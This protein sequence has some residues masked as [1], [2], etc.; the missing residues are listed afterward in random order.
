MHNRIAALLLGAGALAYSAPASAQHHDTSGTHRMPHADA[1]AHGTEQGMDH[2]MWSA[3]LG[4]GWRILG[5]AQVFPVVTI[6]APGQDDDHALRATEWYFTQ[7]ALMLNLEDRRQRVAL[8]TT[9]NPEGAFIEDGELTFGGWGEGFIDKRHP[10]TLLHELMLS[11]NFGDPATT[12]FSVSA[13][14]GFAPYG[15]DDPMARPAL[16]YPTNHH[17]SQILERWTVNAMVLTDGWSL[18]AGIFGGAE[19]E[20]P[21]D[22][23]NIESFGDSWSARVAKRWGAGV[24][25]LAEWEA[26]ASWGSVLEEH[27][28]ESGRTT[29]WNAALRHLRSTSRGQVYG[30]LEASRSEPE[31][32]DGYFSVLGEAR[33]EAGAHQPYARLEYATRPEYARE[34]APGTDGF[35][36]YHHGDDAIGA[37]RW[38]IGTLAYARELT[39]YPFSVRPFAEGQ[40]HRVRAERGGLDPEALFGSDTF[41]SVSLGARVYIG[42]DPMRM[43]A[44]GVLD[45]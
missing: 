9:L 24:G 30:L 29:L 28:G 6:G 36:R 4:Q 27:H 14:K 33:I 37:T 35:F 41:W 1:A 26:S 22:L 11:V 40:Y 25:P 19:P 42:G 21:Y 15:T 13:G 44:Y 23:S 10:H 38:L 16:K 12:A 34:G 5:M 3:E 31:H 8:R 43:G 7:P 39:G 2:E 45:P 32:G 18:E 20:G 17:L